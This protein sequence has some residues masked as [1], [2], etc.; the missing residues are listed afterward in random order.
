MQPD[1]CAGASETSQ[2]VNGHNPIRALRN[3]Q[4]AVHDFIRGRRTVGEKKVVVLEAGPPEFG[5][6]V[7]RI[8]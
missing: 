3:P 4:K 2:T 7:F 1:K 6:I 5:L 8:V